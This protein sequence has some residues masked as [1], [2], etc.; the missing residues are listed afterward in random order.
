MVIIG[1]SAE[2]AAYEVIRASTFTRITG[3]PTGRDRDGLE[4]GIMVILARATIPWFALA[5]KWGLLGEVM[6]VNHYKALTGK[7]CVEEIEPEA[8]DSSIRSVYD[9]KVIKVRLAIWDQKRELY[10][11]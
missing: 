6:S 1:S 5:G 11:I 10:C 4:E 9:N 7:G 3:H 8:F 2:Q